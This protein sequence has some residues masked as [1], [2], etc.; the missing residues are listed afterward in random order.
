M[1][2][3]LLLDCFKACAR[4]KA[5]KPHSAFTVDRRRPNGLNPY[6]RECTRHRNR[7]HYSNNRASESARK[8]TAYRENREQ[9][10]ARNRR[11]RGVNRDRE[12]ETNRRYY[13]MN[14]HRVAA[15]HRLY[16][17]TNKA[18]ALESCRRRRARQRSATTIAFT[19]EQ[20]AAKWEYWGNRCW[21]CGGD[22]NA[23]DHVKPLNKGGAHMLCNLRPI[24]RSCNSAKRDK[25]PYTPPVRSAV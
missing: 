5:A 15:W 19:P 22:A 9:F 23:T 11:W 12:R 2:T 21:T 8:A 14:R 10:L 13:Q 3:Q 25:W 20:L 24:C 4:C 17:E 6:C 16:Y 18:A 7:N 1:T